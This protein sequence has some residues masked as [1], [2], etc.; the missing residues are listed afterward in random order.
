MQQRS[1][2]TRQRIMEA[3]QRLFSHQGYAATGV[4]EI[5]TGAGVSKGAFYHHFAS[6]QAVFLAILEAWLTQIDGAFAQLRQSAA[7]VPDAM[8]SMGRMAGALF[9][10]A[11]VRQA[12]F[13]EF[14]TQAQRDPAVWQAASQ[15][16]RRYQEYFASLIRQGIDEGSLGEVDPQIAGRMTVALGLGLLMMGLFDPH[17]VDWEM[18]TSSYLQY[19]MDGLSRRTA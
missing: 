16:Y 17:G 12:L 5:C 18:E 4:A 9:Q 8:L 3:A 1:E 6:K 2:E 19:L 10:L 11:D 15:P 13:L 7:D 14:W